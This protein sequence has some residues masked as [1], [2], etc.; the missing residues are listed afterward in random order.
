MKAFEHYK[1]TI[2]FITILLLDCVLTALYGL[3][4]HYRYNIFFVHPY[5]DK[6]IIFTVFA[7]LTILFFVSSIAGL[8]K[9]DE[10]RIGDSIFSGI[11]TL[12][13]VNVTTYIQIS[14]IEAK[15]A[16]A[17]PLITLTFMQI[18]IISGWAFISAELIKKLNP[19]QRMLIVY[20]S[21]LATE[22][23]L[24]MSEMVDKY[25]ICESIKTT[26]NLDDI[27]EAIN[28]YESIIICDV[29]AQTRND[30]LKFCYENDKRVYIVPKISDILI[31]GAYEI[32]YF[33]SPLVCC[34]SVGLTLE[35]RVVKRAMDLFVSSLAIMVLSPFLLIVS[36]AIK[37]Y[38]GG[39]VFFRQKRITL[40]GKEFEIYK[41]RSMIVNAEPD[42]KPKP[43]VN[44][45]K[46]ITPIGKLIRP[47]RIDELPQLFNIFI[48]DMS[49]VGPRCERVEHVKEYCKQMPEFAY[50]HKVKTGLTGYAQVYGKYNTTAY[51]KLK[52][53]LT[54]IQNYSVM[55]D[56]KLMLLTI[57]VLF[58]KES[59]EGFDNKKEL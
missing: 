17:L 55:L 48:G 42:G 11:V 2:R 50:R 5:R 27:I 8:Q 34:E 44:N 37:L 9:I 30:L 31:R 58:R 57:K 56:I 33:D 3:V 59:T 43:A 19:P 36:A 12:F 16:N 32:T 35:Q 22:L 15:L 21:H 45:D 51:N 6:G 39:P 25:T 40:D 24:K 1:K 29:S 47:L 20:G 49:I 41:F 53:D 52:L 4:W 28:R 26:E 14:L 46:R 54:Y 23:V 7:Y 38:D 13:F 18:A 10:R